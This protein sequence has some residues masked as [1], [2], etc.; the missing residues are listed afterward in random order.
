MK[1]ESTSQGRQPVA[2]GACQQKVRSNDRKLH[3]GEI[4]KTRGFF[5]GRNQDAI[6][7]GQC[8]GISAMEEQR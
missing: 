7:G 6:N 3:R 2:V 4:S 8:E 5:F 1:L